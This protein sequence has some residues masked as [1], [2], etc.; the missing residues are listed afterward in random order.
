MKTKKYLTLIVIVFLIVVVGST[1]WS[2]VVQKDYLDRVGTPISKEQSGEVEPVLQVVASGLGQIW[3]IDFIP[4]TSQL[5]ATGNSGQIFIIDTESLDVKEINGVPEVESRGQGGLL[6]VA[7]SPEFDEDGKIYFTY[8]AGG[9]EGTATHLARG[10]L[11]IELLI[12]NDVEVLYVATP[13]KRGTSHYGSRVVIDGDYLFVTIG[14]RGDK[15]FDNHVSQDTSNALGATLRLLRDGNIPDDNPFVNDENIL[16][17]IYSYGHRNSQGMAIHP[18]TGDLWQS[19]HGE[20]DGDE[21]NII[22]AGGN[23][24]WPETHTGCGYI[25]G[26]P[27][28]D[29]PWERDDIVEPIHYWECNTGGFPPAGMVF[30]DGEIF[31]D[32]EGDLFVGGLAS[33]YLAHFKV[34]DEEL[35]EQKPLLEEEGWRIRDV[36]V[37]K[38]DGAIYAAVEGQET[39]LVR[40]FPR[41]VE[42]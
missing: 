15:D 37:G 32:W 16:N 35:V 14:D 18:E 41:I 19:E 36:T 1:Y 28:G 21:I 24:G 17:E 33:Q 23:Y 39:S 29:L 26:R 7:V 9:N 4:G 30:Y 20:Q 42:N 27:I 13:F 6:D 3:G 31:Y 25:T 5:V 34:A 38:H 40:I 8:S 2:N 10:I 12:L 22:R 11:D